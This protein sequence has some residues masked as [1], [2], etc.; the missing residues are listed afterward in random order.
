MDDLISRTLPA[1]IKERLKTKP[2]RWLVTGAAGFIGSNLVEALLKFDQTVVGLDNFATGRRENIEDVARKVGGKQA[3]NFEFREG[4]I[5][6]PEACQSACANVDIVLHQAALGSV[7]RSLA[8]PAAT[9]ESNVTGFLNMAIAARDAKAS[10]FVFAAS[11]STYGDNTDLPKV[12]SKIGKPLSPYALTKLV[13]ELYADIFFRCYGLATVGLRYFNVF[14]RRQDPNG[15]YSAVIP[16]WTSALIRGETVEIFGDGTTSR[17]FCYIDNVIQANI[18]AALAPPDGVV[19]EVFNVAFGERTSL[20]D[21]YTELRDI[22]SKDFPKVLEKAAV[23][24]PF[25]AADVMHSLA[26]ITK[27]RER[28]GYQPSHSLRGG[29]TEA[30]KW[31]TENLK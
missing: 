1:Q 6:D 16:R 18:L 22:I 23:H 9:N 3:G 20:N 21:L 10:R 29:L 7:P 30:V 8:N 14:G 2:R 27:A 28:L 5:R 31:Y 13:N 17:D 19:G 15:A 4:D 26:E 24:K 11:S 12:E 25:R